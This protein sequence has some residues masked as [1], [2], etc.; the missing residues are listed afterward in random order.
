MTAFAE[1]AHRS[2][3]AKGHRALRLRTVDRLTGQVKVQGSKNI[4]Q[5]LVPMCASGPGVFRFTDLPFITDTVAVLRIIEH[6]G[7]TIDLDGSDVLIDTRDL[8]NRPIGRQLTV[9]STGTFQFAGALLARFGAVEIAK[10]GGDR[11]GGRP[12]NVH[13]DVFKQF[14]ASVEEVGERYRIT[15]DTLLASSVRLPIRSVGVLVNALLC[16]SAMVEDTTIENI[17][18]DGDILATFDF[19]RALG[20]DVALTGA[21]TSRIAG[22]RRDFPR[23][24]G[25]RTPPDRNDAATWLIAAAACKGPVTVSNVPID[26][27]APLLEFLESIGVDLSVD[28]SAETV[29]VQAEELDTDGVDLRAG[30]SPG[31]HSDWGQAALLLLVRGH[32]NSRFTDTM[33][34]GRYSH[35]PELKRMGATVETEH[36]SVEAGTLMFDPSATEV[37]SVRVVGPADLHGTEVTG[38]DVR[39]SAALTIAGCLAAGETL[40][41]GIDQ[42]ARGYENLTGRLGGL[43]VECEP[44][45]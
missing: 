42:L 9:A 19:M 29:R 43:G 45:C 18:V 41:G 24:A 20:A 11:I 27:V 22:R 8:R 4:A 40:V 28:R 6:L 7:G 13:L 15:A 14:G 33:Y 21:A 36:V 26:D 16:A 23:S 17:P 38:Q 39:G 37:T 5:K 34:E 30:S 12:V 31:F 10:P 25:F 2:D 44:V 3:W 32:G 1:I 35:V